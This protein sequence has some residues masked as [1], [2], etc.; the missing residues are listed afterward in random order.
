MASPLR[1]YAALLRTLQ[2]RG[3][4]LLPCRAYFDRCEPPT[5]YLRHDVDRLSHR[6]V[7]MA[8]VE[9]AL[10]A[11][12]TYYFRCSRAGRFPE[13]AIQSVMQLDHEIGY[14]YET[15]VRSRGDAARAAARFER[16]LAELRR[17]AGVQTVAAHGSPLSRFSN[18][19]RSRGLELERLG[20]LGEPGLDFDF[21]RVLYVT[22]T[23]G[24]F[25]SPHNVRD[26]VA[27]R[28]LPRRATP[29][30]LAE[31]LQPESEPLVLL[32][33]HPER[34]PATAIGLCQAVVTDTVVNIAKS[35]VRHRSA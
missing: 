13:A 2:S 4:R 5:V 35:L 16:E 31:L 27:G 19:G 21:E 14:H 28:N 30:N 24:S 26:R 11:N 10:G 33:T 20:L 34:W 15:F 7:R 1:E 29:S 6:S 22:D 3:Y 9:A 25:G 23:G 18:I 32:N 17:L 12:A 8:G